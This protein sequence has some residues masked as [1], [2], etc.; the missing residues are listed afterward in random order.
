MRRV[1]I[2]SIAA[3]AAESALIRAES[4]NR[5][6]GPARS[7]VSD[8]PPRRPLE[9]AARGGT[10]A[11]HRPRRRVVRAACVR[12]GLPG[13]RLAMEHGF[14]AGD[15]V[16]FAG[17][18]LR[19]IAEHGGYLASWIGTVD[20]VTDRTVVVRWDDSPTLLCF[21]RPSDL[22]TVGAAR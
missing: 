20:S 16:R 10:A 6:N 2:G 14:N 21:G 7:S 11:E 15:R 13:W 4:A 17:D 9:G 5:P 22:E 18:Y 12:A 8:S 1:R 19:R 3:A